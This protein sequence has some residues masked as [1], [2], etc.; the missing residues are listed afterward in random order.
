[1][2]SKSIKR[3]PSTYLVS[4]G[5][6]PNQILKPIKGF[7]SEPLVSLEEACQPLL[8]IIPRL[9]HYVNDAKKNSKNPANNLTQD[10]SAAI[11]L[12]TMQWDSN[13][14]DPHVSLYSHLNCILRQPDR[15]VLK[16]WFCYLKLFLTA[17]AKLP[18]ISGQNFWRG[19]R[20]EYT[21][22]YIE[23]D[24][25]IWWGFSSCTKSLQ[26]LKSD[27]FLGTTDKRS[28]FSIEIFDG[29][30]VKDHSDFPEEE[31]VLLFPGTCLKVDAKLNPASDLHIIQLKSI[32]PHD[33]LLES[34]LQDDPWTHKIVPGNTFWLLTQKYGCS[35]DEIIAANQDIDPLK[36]QVDQLVQ[37][38]SACRKPRTKIA[39]DEH[40]SDQV[41]H[42]VFAGD[43][44]ER[45]SEWYGC[46][47]EDIMIANPDIQPTSIYPGQILRL[48][49]TYRTAN[50]TRD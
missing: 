35:L 2:T 9:K 11:R 37:L 26:V 19:I 23:D 50:N 22:K 13:L 45:I 29:R 3:E 21:A 14:D 34:V 5:D 33:E 31:E 10:E 25:T 46:T 48:P 32:H 42:T 27:A 47:I 4:A 20:N 30:S 43:T 17:L 8:G 36:L 44:C 39:L 6:K 18:P 7:A 38:P 28:I 49:R 15:K 40:R 12:Y 41:C 16:P 1:M 24:E